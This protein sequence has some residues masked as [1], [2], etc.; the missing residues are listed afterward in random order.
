MKT[1]QDFIN[2]FK[3]LLQKYDAS[4]EIGRHTERDNETVLITWFSKWDRQDNQTEDFTEIDLLKE[5]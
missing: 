3:D 2:D 1:K 4:I 5:I